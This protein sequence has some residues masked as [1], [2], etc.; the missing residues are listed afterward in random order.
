MRGV[1]NGPSSQQV[2]LSECAGEMQSVDQGISS[3]GSVLPLDVALELDCTE[4]PTGEEQNTLLGS[5][6]NG[7]S[8]KLVNSRKSIQGPST[9]RLCSQ[10]GSC[11]TGKHHVQ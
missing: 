4:R 5:K 9:P 7:R 3:I 1:T 8:W 11:A 6:G 10:L 2:P